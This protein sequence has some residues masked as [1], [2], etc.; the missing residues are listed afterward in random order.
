MEIF[1]TQDYSKFKFL[2]YNRAVGSNKK[3]SKSI[4]IAN[5]TP[6]CPIIVTPDMEIIDGQNRFEVCKSKEMPIYY[7]V[8]DGDA[9]TAMKALNTCAQPWR[10]EEWLQYYLAKEVPNYV[11]LKDFMDMYNLPISNAILIFSNGSTNAT[12]FKKGNLNRTGKYHN[13]I[14]V[15]LNDVA[16]VLPRDIVRFR[17]FVNGVMLFFNEFGGNKR[18]VEKLKKKIASIYKYNRTEDYLNSFRNYVK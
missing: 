1:K 3:L 13:E 17:A 18:K 11:A 14:A 9:E 7:V 12:T 16:S 8:Y 10:Q 6:V 5:L 2:S 4:E 15:F